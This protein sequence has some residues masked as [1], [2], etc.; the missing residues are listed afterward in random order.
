MLSAGLFYPQRICPPP[1]QIL[2]EIFFIDTSKLKWCALF[3]TKMRIQLRT[4]H[5]LTDLAIYIID[6]LM[7]ED[8]QQ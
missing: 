2:I 5:T 1:P 3:R 6:K 4:Q 8:L 7:Q